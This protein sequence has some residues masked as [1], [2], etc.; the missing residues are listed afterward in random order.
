M[1]GRHS[2]TAKEG[3]RSRVCVEGKCLDNLVSWK[4]TPHLIRSVFCY[5]EIARN[6]Y[7]SA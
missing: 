1:L 2:I 7:T 3:A 4:H 5:S 6:N